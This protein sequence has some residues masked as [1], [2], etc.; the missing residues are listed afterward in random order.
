MTVKQL[1]VRQ[2]DQAPAL[3]IVVPSYNVAPYIE[4]AIV[5]ALDQSFTDLEVIVVNDGSTDDTPEVIER[6]AAARCDPRLKVVHRTNGGLAA[7]R[8]TGI[9]TASGAYIGFLDSDDIWHATKAEKHLRQ[10][11]A[12]PS[13][14]ISFS[15]SAYL[16]EDGQP[17][18]GYLFAEKMTPSLHDMIRRNH[19]GNG[20]TPIVRRDC[21]E[22]AG[23]FREE[24]KSCEDYEMW[25]RILWSTDYRAEAIAEPLTFYRL[26][27]SSLSFNFEKFTHN[28]DLAMLALRGSMKNVPDRVFRAGHAGHYRV[29]AVKAVLAQQD[30]AA[31]RLLR[32]A[33]QLWPWLVLQDFRAS[34]AA[35]A[36]M[37]PPQPRQR[38][39]S[40]YKSL[41]TSEVK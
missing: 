38:L 9:E 28:A 24:L 17:T 41:R 4:A 15:H 34:G 27:D 10:M 6:V 20:S 40:W 37:I 7:A 26:R 21:F 39:M 12:D 18:G 35:I 23:L 1:P 11:R 5:S 31:A 8:N 29:A 16:R 36:L 2:F 30:A 32:E 19:V 25:C 13:I 22:R 3:S 33:L 14:G